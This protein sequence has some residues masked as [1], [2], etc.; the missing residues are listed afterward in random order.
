V[1]RVIIALATSLGLSMLMVAATFAWEGRLEGRPSSLRA[2]ISY[3]VYVW[4]D[5]DA[6][7]LRTSAS[8]YYNHVFSGTIVTDG[9]IV[10]LHLVETEEDDSVYVSPNGRTL[11][12]SMHTY[13]GIDGFV[14]AIAGGTYQKVSAY[15]NGNLMEVQNL[16]LGVN[17]VNPEFNPFQDTR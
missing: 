9:A 15:N 2:G 12:Y 10:N 5:A 16:H 14:Y 4:H 17:A 7:H 6:L 3:G 1:K 11:T 8:T 13:D